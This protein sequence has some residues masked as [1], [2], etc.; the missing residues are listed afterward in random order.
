MKKPAM[1]IKLKSFPGLGLLAMKLLLAS[2]LAAA[3]QGAFTNVT[4]VV[5]PVGSL[6]TS[7]ESHTA[8]LLPN[9]QVLVAGGEAVEYGLEDGLAS[10]PQ[11]IV[12][13]SAELYD[14]VAG[15]W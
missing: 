9:G 6:N 7:R 4:T 5:T 13:K 2:C 12:F 10:A 1:N 11:F 8:T 15:A 3:A 14:P